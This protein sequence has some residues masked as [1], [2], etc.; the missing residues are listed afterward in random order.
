M[1]SLNVVLFSVFAASSMSDDWDMR[2]VGGYQPM[3]TQSIHV[4]M[5]RVA[6]HSMII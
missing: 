4:L 2:L 5:V 1:M 6:F 3:A